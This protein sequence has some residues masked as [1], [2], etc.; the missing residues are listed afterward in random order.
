MKIL[1]TGGTGLIGRELG[2]ALVR[3]GHELVIV[4]RDA[5]K[6]RALCPFPCRF[7][8]GDLLKAALV[9]PELDG[10]NAVFHLMGESIADG[11]WTEAKKKALVDSRVLSARHLRA[12]LRGVETMI[13]ASAIGIYGDRGDEELTEASAPAA[14]FLGTLCVQWE[15]A[16]REFAED[17]ARVLSLRL[18]V[19]LSHKGGALPELLVPFRAGVGGPLAGGRAWMSWIHLDDVVGLF[20]HALARTDLAG[21]MN[22][23][24][25]Q[26]VRNAEFTRELSSLLRR[27][28]FL[29]VP[30][31]GL[32]LLF[33][34]KASALT[35][36]AKVIPR[37]A[38]ESG[39]VFRFPELRSAL[40]DQ[41][42][43]FEK[44]EDL[45]TA[46]QYLPLP[47]E[48]LFPFFADARNLGAL[49]PDDMDFRIESTEPV[50]LSENARI[51]YRLKVHGLP[52]HWVTRIERWSPPF[53][54]VD[55]QEKGP[56]ALWRHTH[57]FE[58]LGPGTL[59]TDEVTYRLPFGYFGWLGGSAFVGGDL[60]RL[61]AYRREVID[62]L[63]GGGVRRETDSAASAGL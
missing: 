26:P 39:Y 30:E 8:E 32:K 5:K 51:R 53:E 58:K 56:Y 11:R 27:P 43:P 63:Y 57:R 45:L 35:A 44:G 10:V 48:E 50:E 60:E 7:A 61:F 4:T 36:S 25:P 37:R 2:K 13:S 21:V 52:I 12:S 34:E 15:K 6:A 59:M 54:F 40:R 28:G 62:R 41:L 49:T 33:G 14:D 29:P 42:A 9:S 20:R 16:A 1:I 47:P 18:G 31:A 22:A 17:G 38:L 3:D 23:T 19:V 46:E 55:I 24:S